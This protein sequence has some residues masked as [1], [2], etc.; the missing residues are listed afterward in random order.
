M[1]DE[2]RFISTDYGGIVLSAG[3]MKGFYELGVLQFYHTEG[4]F[5]KIK[6]LSGTSIG[7]FIAS[8]YCIGYTPEEIRDMA[9]G[10]QLITSEDADFHNLDKDFGLY[11]T[12]RLRQYLSNLF[13]VKYKYI[14]TMIDIFMMSGKHLILCT[15]NVTKTRMEY[16]NWKTEPNMLITD[17]IIASCSIPGLLKAFKYKGDYYTDGARGEICPLDYTIKYIKDYSTR[18][19]MCITFTERNCEKFSDFLNNLMITRNIKPEDLVNYTDLAD[20]VFLP[21]HYL[22]FDI[23]KTSRIALYDEGLEY[24]TNL[25]KTQNEQISKKW[26]EI[27]I[28]TP[29]RHRK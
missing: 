21:N 24:I 14:P 11:K 6:V 19:I 17:A 3:G 20:I 25:L 8:L 4:Y 22:P 12:D 10:I 18:R 23:D 13:K 26:P 16:I 5:D 28:K 27:N 15:Y 29:L 1:N 2:N 7:G 9:L